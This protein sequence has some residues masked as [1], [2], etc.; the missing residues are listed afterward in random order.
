MTDQIL[1]ESTQAAARYLAD[2]HDVPRTIVPHL[3]TKF[4][5]TSFQAVQAIQAAQRMRAYRAAHA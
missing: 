5:L 1:D 2:L 3:K 4:G